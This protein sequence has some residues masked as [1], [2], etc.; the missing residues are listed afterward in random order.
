MRN[1]I[2]IIMCSLLVVLCSQKML[3]ADRNAVYAPA[4]SV[5]VERLLRESKALKASDNKVIFFARRLIG[6][7]YVAH[8]LEVADPERLVVNT[9][10][11]DCTTLV[12][13][14]TA[15]AL[16]SA[17]KKYR[18]GDYLSL[19]RTIRYRGGKISGYTSRIHYFSEWIIDNTRKGIVE[20]VE[21]AA[22]P[23]MARETLRLRFMGDNSSKYAMLVK[24]PEMVAEIRRHERLL[25][26]MEAYYIPKHLVKDSPETRRAISDGDIIAIT[27]SKQGLDIAHVGF[28][29]WKKDGL[30]L[31]HASM[32]KKKVV[33]D[34]EPLG[35][36]LARHKTFT[37]I[38]VVRIMNVEL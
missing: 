17:K 26:G 19:L 15:L 25:D 13:N 23:F 27:T 14:V 32:T 18:F 10:Q 33:E 37:G 12:E 29:I 34:T 38:R 31:L 21:H 8:T 22:A 24:H 6:K 1:Y 30:H 3:S 4:D 2:Y 35:A 9:R 16:C 11:L 5:L 28:A 7:P 20:E 36:Y